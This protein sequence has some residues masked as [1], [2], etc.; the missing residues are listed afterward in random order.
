MQLVLVRHGTALSKEEDPARPL[1]EEG[2]R[3]VG[4][5]ASFLKPLGLAP[6]EVWHSGKARAEETACI[7]AAAMGVEDRLVAREGLGPD[8]PP[9]PVADEISARGETLMLVGHLPFLSRLASLLLVGAEAPEVLHFRTASAAC[10]ERSGE[11]GWRVAW[12]L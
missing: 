2:R 1:S 12:M 4:Q 3:E 11:A 5:A 9:G 6:A 10:L 7:L 8:D